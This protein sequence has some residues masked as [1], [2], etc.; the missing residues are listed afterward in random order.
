MKIAYIM[1]RFPLLSETFIL[2]EMDEVEAQ[3]S[4]IALYPLICQDQDVVHEEAKKWIS[5]RNCVSFFSMD[6]I[7]ANLRAF[8][9]H[10]IKQC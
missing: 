5:R 4:Q 1:S 8:I 9:K 2:R 6:L 7:P 3:G 10:P